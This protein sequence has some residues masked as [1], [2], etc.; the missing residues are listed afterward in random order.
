[1]TIEHAG[2]PGL[3]APFQF[4]LSI[5]IFAGWG[6]VARSIDLP[7]PLL[8]AII[9]GAGA[10]T[11]AA[12]KKK[13][14]KWHPNAIIVGTI[15]A[16]DLLLLILAY[17]RIDFA[18]AV[19]L[20]NAGPILVIIL[21]PLIA[22]DPFRLR[23]LLLAIAGCMAVAVVCGA[24]I[25]EGGAQTL[26]GVGF[27]MMSAVTLALSMLVQR[28]LMKQG[29][30]VVNTVLQYNIVLCFWYIVAM[31]AWQT[32]EYNSGFSS[33]SI[34]LNDIISAIF[35]GIMTQGGAMLLFNSAS[36][37][38]NSD[39]MAR[40]SLLGPVIT[41]ILGIVFY[42]ETPN[43]IQV[44]GIAVILATSLGFHDKSLSQ[45]RKS[46]LLNY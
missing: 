34:N 18:T 26:S 29:E 9:C 15:L 7:P 39:I 5:S 3:A 23:S 20:H 4:V 10:A 2:R 42:Y 16:A 27:A 44:M 12:M 24:K 19:A 21:A 33:W 22:G 11:C 40:L 45:P 14:L 17:R 31:I 43:I 38:L 36:R 30:D 41:I 46:N 1:M 13:P 25:G 37:Q 32:I 8:L 28:R 35:A 6:I